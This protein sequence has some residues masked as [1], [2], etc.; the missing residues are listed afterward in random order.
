[1]NAP[2]AKGCTWNVGREQ[3]PAILTAH[4]Q[5]LLQCN[6]PVY[7]FKID[8]T[9]FEM[10]SWPRKQNSSQQGASSDG[11][12][13]KI[14]LDRT[15]LEEMGGFKTVKTEEPPIIPAPFP[16]RSTRPP[17]LST[18]SSSLSPP[19]DS[20]P[21]TSQVPQVATIPP[22]PVVRGFLPLV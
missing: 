16:P 3:R 10:L 12:T 9:N 11:H 20:S 17:L 21:Q 18:S 2:M 22:T 1:M 14:I 6:L 19:P 5:H 4:L 13:T 7:S 15:I 8:Y